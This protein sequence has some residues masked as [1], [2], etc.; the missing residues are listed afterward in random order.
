MSKQ[1]KLT[2]HHAIA[3]WALNNWKKDKLYHTIDDEILRSVAA[4]L[5]KPFQLV[6]EL[7]EA[8]LLVAV[9]FIKG[10]TDFSVFSLK[11]IDRA[12][13]YFATIVAER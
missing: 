4:D 3:A 13:K 9:V 10:E 7:D 6:Q 5:N 1:K 12:I 11:D 2:K 8:D